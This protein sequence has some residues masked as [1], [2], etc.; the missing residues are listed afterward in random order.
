MDVKRTDWE[1]CV[2]AI[3][4]KRDLRAILPSE[5]STIHRELRNMNHVQIYE[6][7][8]TNLTSLAK[9][10]SITTYIKPT[11]QANP[12]LTQTIPQTTT[13]NQAHLSLST[14]EYNRKI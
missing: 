10:T 14:H 1:V 5:H 4:N 8:D 12:L 6:L 7:K 2:F 3:A 11:T 13:C 9:R